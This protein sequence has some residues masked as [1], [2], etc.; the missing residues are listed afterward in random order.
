M[1]SK[2][3]HKIITRENDDVDTIKRI[4]DQKKPEALILESGKCYCL[5]DQIIMNQRTLLIAQNLVLYG[6]KIEKFK[7]YKGELLKVILSLK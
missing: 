1:S 7:Y 2:S 4:I 6:W 3:H 5:R